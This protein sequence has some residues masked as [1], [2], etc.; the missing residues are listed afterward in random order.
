[1]G[2][3]GAGLI[4]YNHGFKQTVWVGEVAS[5]TTN[6]TQ[7]N[8][9]SISYC[10]VLWIHGDWQGLKKCIF[11]G[12]VLIF[13]SKFSNFHPNC[14]ISHKS[15]YQI[16]FF[17]H[18]DDWTVMVLSLL[19]P[20]GSVATTPS[21]SSHHLVTMQRSDWVNMSFAEYMVESSPHLRKQR[22]IGHTWLAWW[23]LI[24]SS[25]LYTFTLGQERKKPCSTGPTNRFFSPFADF[26]FK[27]K[28]VKSAVFLTK[29]FNEK[30]RA[31]RVRK[32]HDF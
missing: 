10:S 24:F 9:Y 26:F 7:H 29:N 28:N 20:A 25:Y 3:C 4:L 21:L 30:L 12:K 23:A 31:K 16:T 17:S 8:S 14:Q 1:M 32:N 19:L 27:K 6:M 13:P 15:H 11:P 22:F 5:L 2:D 18:L